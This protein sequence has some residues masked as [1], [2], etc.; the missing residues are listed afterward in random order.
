MPPIPRRGAL[1]LAAASLAAPTLAAPALAQARFPDRPIRLVI[2]WPAGGSADSQ[3]RSMSEIAGRAL[4]QPVVCENK[5][6]AGGTLGP[7][8]V[9]QQ[10]RPDGYS[11][12]QMH[13]S[14]LRRPWMMK[15][16]LWNPVTDFTHIIGLTGWLFGTAVKADSRFGTWQEMITYARAN[17]GK[18]TYST[19]GIGT[20]NHLAMETL[21]E[22]EKV[23]ITHVP[24]RG[25]NEGV[26]AALAGQVDMVS[27][28]SAWAPF[29]EA[30][31]MRALSVWTAER[32]ARFPTVPT[33]RE[34]GYDMEVTSPYGVSGPRGMDEGVVRVLHDAFKA[35]LF[36][37]EN[38]RIRGQF[39]MPLV[40]RDTA[41]YRDFVAQR[42]DYEKT[43]VRRLNLTL[44]G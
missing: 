33:L 22:L 25:S 9:A 20:S 5:P 29:V 32:A 8:T 11:L 15:A 30:G 7:M 1:A 38:E 44:D 41:A 42:V 34:L 10:S 27:D 40:Y 26:T 24:F 39:D 3:L 16:P 17:P 31:S 14:V 43:M 19:S 2:P 36:D 18:L 28:S 37:P 35:A 13:L 12:T 6:G 23:E 21:L 4:G